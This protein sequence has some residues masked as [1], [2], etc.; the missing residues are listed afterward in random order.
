MASAALRRE[1][2][3]NDRHVLRARMRT[4]AG[5]P[6]RRLG[7][8]AEEALRLCSLPGEETGR[9]YHFHRLYITGLPEGG[10]RSIWLE[11]FQRELTRLANSAV[12]GADERAASADA[13]FFHNQSEACEALLALLVRRRPADAWFWAV[14]SASAPGAPPAERLVDLIEILRASPASWRAV[15]GAV[16]TSLEADDAVPLFN[17]LPEAAAARWLRELGD[18]HPPWPAIGVPASRQMAAEQD[19]DDADGVWRA[20][21]AV[22]FPRSMQS[23]LARATAA[24]S[25]NDSRVLWLASLAVVLACPSELEKGVVLRRARTSISA[26]APAMPRPRPAE[27]IA[28]AHAHRFRAGRRKGRQDRGYAKSNRRHPKSSRRRD[29]AN[30]VDGGRK[31]SF[32]TGNDRARSGQRAARSGL[33]GG[34]L[35]R[36]VD[37]GSRSLL[38]AQCTL[39]AENRR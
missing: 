19:Q 27:L 24:L 34:L 7:F 10:D 12:H 11:A 8:L 15:A 2:G 36:P 21:L 17:L 28:K 33:A 5:A 32:H 23:V 25:R 26:I 18:D 39:P 3:R 38:S 35:L 9:V 4:R 30:A 16:M 14:V 31:F 13:V 22:E 20:S 1:P 29:P 6:W 37:A